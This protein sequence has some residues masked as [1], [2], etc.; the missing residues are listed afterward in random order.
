MR[1]IEDLRDIY[2][3]EEIWV[4]GCGPSIGD[5][6]KG[7][8]DDKIFIGLNE[9][10]LLFPNCTFNCS[11]HGH[12]WDDVKQNHPALLEKL[13]LCYPQFT[14]ELAKTHK[15]W[16]GSNEKYAHDWRLNWIEDCGDKP[17]YMKWYD[18]HPFPPIDE[19]KK[20]LKIVVESIVNKV[21]TIY[22]SLNTV[23]HAGI[24]AAMILGARKI[25]LAGCDEASSKDG[26]HTYV[27]IFNS[28]PPEWNAKNEVAAGLLASERQGN[29]GSWY[30]RARYGTGCLVE[31]FGSYGFDIQKYFIGEGY[32]RIV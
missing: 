11:I 4:V 10:Y 21:P 28:F 31:V 9:A 8:F 25:T 26:T 19:I 13:I 3:G 15:A 14:D 27:E 1:H 22:P 29:M 30:I 5:F 7:F 23:S 18:S 32:R 6:P 12:I 2:S 24:Q 16:Q 17:I 20:R